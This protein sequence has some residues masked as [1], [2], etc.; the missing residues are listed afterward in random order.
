[1]N[2]PAGTVF[3]SITATCVHPGGCGTDGENP[4]SEWEMEGSLITW[5]RRV[6]IV[7]WIAIGLCLLIAPYGRTASSPSC[8][9]TTHFLVLTISAVALSNAAPSL[10][11][12]VGKPYGNY[13]QQQCQTHY[14]SC[15]AGT[16]I[17]MSC[18]T[19]TVFDHT[20][21]KC[22]YPEACGTQRPTPPPISNQQHEAV[23]SSPL[24][25]GLSNYFPAPQPQE[26]TP[27]A[28]TSVTPSKQ[29]GFNCA[30]LMDG[31]YYQDP[32]TSTFVVC[33]AG[34]WIFGNLSI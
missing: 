4:T 34:E 17:Q 22:D 5:A 29:Y 30:G 2:C 14:Y 21:G 33:L 31:Y 15:N 27:P 19:G 24:E 3:D 11:S 9:T 10:G 26:Q 25:H 18:S 1:M 7:V 16:A 6:C 20:V 23:P 12:C 32:C 13:A 28:T 8:I